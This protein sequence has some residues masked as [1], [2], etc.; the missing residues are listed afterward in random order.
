MAGAS[1]REILKIQKFML[2]DRIPDRGPG[3]LE[4]LIEATYTKERA[5]H[6][7]RANLGI[8]RGAGAL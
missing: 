3:R 4:A 6:L 8:D 7:R 1:S 2:G 5:Q